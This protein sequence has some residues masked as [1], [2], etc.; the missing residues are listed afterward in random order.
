MAYN[1]LDEI[2]FWCESQNLNHLKEPHE[3][4]CKSTLLNK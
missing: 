3:I 2:S 1:Q 4:D